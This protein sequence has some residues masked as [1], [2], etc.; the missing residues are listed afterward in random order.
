MKNANKFAKNILILKE[1][2]SNEKIN[3]CT[4]IFIMEYSRNSS[5]CRK[6]TKKLQKMVVK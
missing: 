4:T 3:Q 6:I 5:V 1:V 2:M